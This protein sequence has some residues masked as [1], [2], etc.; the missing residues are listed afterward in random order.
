MKG[1]VNS[2][3]IGIAEKLKESKI[4]DEPITP[5]RIID[6]IKVQIKVRSVN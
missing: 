5:F 2:N 4:H 6:M 1:S 3:L